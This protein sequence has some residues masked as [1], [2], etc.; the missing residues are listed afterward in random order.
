MSQFL[1]CKR[2]LSLEVARCNGVNGGLT[3]SV[4]A[5]ACGCVKT[6]GLVE[7]PAGDGLMGIGAYVGECQLNK[8]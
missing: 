4:S 2:D 3:A 6:C 7:G 1:Q 8:W 5:W